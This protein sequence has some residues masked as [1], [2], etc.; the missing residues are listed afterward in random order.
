L[1]G[2]EGPLGWAL[3]RE[4][5]FDN[6]GQAQQFERGFMFKGSGDRI[7]VLLDNG[8]FYAQ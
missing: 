3:D 2:P 8:R 5:G 1:G 4:Y 7:Y 6:V